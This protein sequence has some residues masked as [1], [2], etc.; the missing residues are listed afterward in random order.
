MSYILA[1]RIR[2]DKIEKGIAAAKKAGITDMDEAKALVAAKWKAYRDSDC[3]DEKARI[4]YRWA[5]KVEL[6]CRAINRLPIGRL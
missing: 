6:G 5:L 1:A 4:L 3:K 2:A